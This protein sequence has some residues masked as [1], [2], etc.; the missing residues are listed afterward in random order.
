MISSQ[1]NMNRTLQTTNALKDFPENNEQNADDFIPHETR[2]SRS[3][4]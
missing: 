1:R 3:T 4:L 2:R